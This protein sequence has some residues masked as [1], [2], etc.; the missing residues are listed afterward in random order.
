MRSSMSESCPF[1]NGRCESIKEQ[2]SQSMPFD[3][4]ISKLPEAT[5]GKHATTCQVT[6]TNLYEKVVF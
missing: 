6:Q 4:N 5:I 3:L 1:N 2:M